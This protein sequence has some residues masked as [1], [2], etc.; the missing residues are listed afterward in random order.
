MR[1]F[2]YFI[3]QLKRTV[4][5]AVGVFPT[6]MLLF[7][8]LGIAAYIFMNHGPMMQNQKKYQ[9]G[10]VGNIEDS[11]LGFGIF[12]VQTLDDSR[13]M[14]DF[15]PMTEE[16]AQ[17]AFRKAALAAY[18]IIPDEFLASVISGANDTPITYVASEGQK[19]IAGYLMDEL[20]IVKIGR[21]H[22]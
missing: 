11:Y 7:A 4:K 6:A 16:E 14:V 8:C 17:K 5:L 20:A 2:K 21:A 19:G 9:I 18:V 15:I 22:V 10:I 1:Y 3:V 12:A 13:F